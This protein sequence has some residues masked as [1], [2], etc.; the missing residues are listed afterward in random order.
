M[1]LRGC[2]LKQR[3]VPTGKSS[4]PSEPLAVSKRWSLHTVLPFPGWLPWLKEAPTPKTKTRQKAPRG[5]TLQVKPFPIFIFL[6]NQ[7]H[8]ANMYIPLY[9]IEHRHVTHKKPRKVHSW[10]SLSQSGTGN[11]YA[12]LS[13]AP[14]AERV[15]RQGWIPEL[16]LPKKACAP[17]RK[18]EKDKSLPEQAKA[19]LPARFAGYEAHNCVLDQST[20]KMKCSPV[21]LAYGQ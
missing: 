14:P 17:F 9:L 19:A 8:R 16:S 3:D 15:C 2:V 20:G 7:R 10:K 6:R 12:E 1:A 11:S 5:P 13:K 21:I 4:L 18:A